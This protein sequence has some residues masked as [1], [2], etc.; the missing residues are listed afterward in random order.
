MDVVAVVD[1]L[2]GSAQKLAP[3]LDL[4]RKAVNCDLKIVLNPKGKLSELP[5]KRFYR[6]V[7][8]PEL[9]F[10]E[11]GNVAANQAKYVF[12]EVLRFEANVQRLHFLP[13]VF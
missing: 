8:A 7:G 13:E 9:Q 3:I 6:Y 2:S 10:D 1:P 5:L 4:L 12:Y 11:A